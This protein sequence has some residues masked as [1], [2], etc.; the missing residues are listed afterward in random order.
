MVTRLPSSCNSADI[1]GFDGKTVFL[2]AAGRRECVGEIW[3][4]VHCESSV[5]TQQNLLCVKLLCSGL[6]RVIDKMTIDCPAYNHL[7]QRETI[8][9]FKRHKT[10]CVVGDLATFTGTD[11]APCPEMPFGFAWRDTDGMWQWA[12]QR[13]A[14]PIKVL[15]NKANEPPSIAPGIRGQFPMIT[16]IIVTW[17]GPF[18][19]SLVCWMWPTGHSLTYT[20]SGLNK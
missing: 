18:R 11:Q 4:W 16:V 13:L 12:W 8:V 7:G 9:F 1:L 15:G 19:Q 5:S 20:W 3:K 10:T 6:W 14:L 17:F 2:L